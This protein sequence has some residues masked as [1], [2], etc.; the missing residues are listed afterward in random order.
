MA[1]DFTAIFRAQDKVSSQL[2][3]INKSGSALSGTFKKLAAT[4]AGVF[5][6]AKI[7]DFGKQS[8]DSFIDFENGMN[9]VFTLLPDISGQAMDEMSSQVKQFSKDFSMLPETV[10]PALYQALSAGVP[11]DTVFSFLEAANKAA[12]GGVTTLETA[13][14]GLT[15]VVNSYGSDVID[16]KKASDLMFM[17]AKFGKTDFAEL[18]NSLFN[19]LPSASASKVAFEDVSAALAALTAQGVPTSVATTRVRT[20]IDE[21][22]KSGTKTDKVFRQIAGK[23]FK[24]FIAEGGNLQGALQLL[25]K[26]A[27]KNNL[28][29]NDLF[30]SIEAGGAALG[31]TGRGTES[32][33]N[34]MNEMANASGAT[35]AAFEK[36]EQGFKRKIEKMKAN[37]EVLKLNVGGKLVD[38]FNYLWDK[39][40]P[41]IDSIS[42]KIEELR[43]VFGTRGF[44][45]GIEK[46]FGADAGAIAKM[47]ES[48]AM[49]YMGGIKKIFSGDIEGG[50]IDIMKAMG[51]EDSTIN[52]VMNSVNGIWE[53]L[54][55]V[56]SIVQ[57]IFAVVKDTFSSAMGTIQEVMNYLAQKVA[58]IFEGVF[59]FVVD[60][61][62][63]KFVSF[64]ET[65]IP[66]IATIFSGTWNI[67]KPMLDVLLSTIK[68]VWTNVS[69]IISAAVDAMLWLG[70]IVFSALAYVAENFEKVKPL[71]IA[72]GVAFTLWNLDSIIG[73]AVKLGASVLGLG[74]NI[75]TTTTAI[76]SGVT[77]KI[78]DK[79]A[80]LQ[81]AALYAGDFIKSIWTC[82]SA[83]GAQTKAYITNGLQ[84]VAQKAGLVAL[85][86]VQL[87]S[88]GA[89]M[90]LATAQWALNAAFIA[91]P[92]GW[93][94]LGIGA[95]I[96]IGV[97]LYKNWD[98]VKEKA[99][100]LWN[101][102]VNV[103]SPI[104]AW[105]GSLWN[106]VTK[107]FDN[108]MASFSNKF[109]GL[110]KIIEVPINTIKSI[111]NSLKN[112]FGGIVDFV[113]GIFTGD[114]GRAWEGVKSIFK[115]I[116]DTAITIFM[117]PVELIKTAV[118]VFVGW[119]S[120][121]WSIAWNGIVTIFSSLWNGIVAIF[122]Y[123]IALIKGSFTAFQTWI[124]GAWGMLW[125]G[126]QTMFVG[127]MGYLSTNFPMIA[128]LVMVPINTIST[129]FDGL[130]LIFSGLIDFVTGV[131]TGNW[132]QAWEGVKSIFGGIFKSIVAL[133]KQPMNG[134][135][136]IINGAIRGIN[137]LK[138]DIPDWVPMLGGKTFGIN[139][140]EIP[141]FAK[142]TRNSPDTFIAGEEGPELITGKK[143]SQ[144]FPA[145]DTDR[146]I[147]AL[148]KSNQPISVDTTP[149]MDNRIEA[150]TEGVTNEKS[151][152][153]NLN[154]SG[155]IKASGMNKDQVLEIL[156]EYIKP[157]L[158]DILS[159]EVFE[160]GVLSYDF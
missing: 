46:L 2:N 85:K 35:D 155:S 83:I 16:V 76:W 149:F 131:F 38:A 15:T 3:N 154:G 100:A 13:V 74:T 112:V 106:S 28:G 123:P 51:F 23:G 22:S 132:Q 14:D 61:I 18:S 8:V 79:V 43:D 135:I 147:S 57:P 78:A 26:E 81:I 159:T 67:I 66:K 42:T 140:P 92:I 113:A 32:F 148:D 36:M 54:Q 75:A 58:P 139:I 48:Y 114:W 118:A 109:P 119:I 142:G 138:L 90:A 17:T 27:A 41:I 55:K 44:S 94:V 129:M 104:V 65:N 11:Q 70:D 9:E 130:K 31:L 143:G 24:D 34:A 47:A 29:I 152:N 101:G 99:S 77:A 86:A 156:I 7:V 97:L 121:A 134:V 126:L 136:A 21:L 87:V 12:V 125:G 89:T 72:F 71:I 137:N 127:F 128:N 144:V 49:A 146:I 108:F 157:I 150:N 141:M 59:G 25:E 158:I 60:T 103:F 50:T 1:V 117:Y 64:W 68:N 133:V 82:V 80:T 124:T 98:T 91:S 62:L 145:N 37:I 84:L 30:S 20:V 5:T 116:W 93:V 115:G 52:I 95:L 10:V 33:T 160:E 107:V 19:V 4:A 111:L 96:A 53:S 56:P 63:P 69:P 88:Q 40:M 122:S 73:T 6:A 153:I 39:T 105:F 110:A 120:N 102:L 45:G 151:I